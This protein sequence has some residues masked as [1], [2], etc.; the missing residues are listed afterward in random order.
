MRGVGT[1][2]DTTTNKDTPRVLDLS[3]LASRAGKTLTG[4][5]RVELAYLRRFLADSAPCFFL[6]RTSHGFVLMDRAGGQAFEKAVTT[7]AWGRADLQS[8]LAR[9]KRHEVRAAHSL[10]RRHRIGRGRH[11]R[12]VLLLT[13]YL[14]ENSELYLIGH[15]NL[16]EATLQAL[17]VG[18]GGNI[19]VMIHDTI[20]LDYPETQRQR[21]VERFEDAIKAV[22]KHAARVICISDFAAERVKQH[23]EKAGNVPEIVVSHLGVD[24][25]NPKFAEVPKYIDL[26]DDYFVI[27][28]TIEPRKNHMLLLEVWQS[29]DPENRPRLFVCGSRGWLNKTVFDRLDRGIKGVQE[30]PNL[31]DGA[32]AAV[33]HGSRALLCPS[34]VEGFGLT[35]VEAA[36]MGVPVICSS[37]PV[38]REILG[39]YADYRD[40]RD[41]F[42][43]RT[44]VNEIMGVS[45]EEHVTAFVPSTWEQHF[46]KVFGTK[47]A[48]AKPE[49]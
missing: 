2:V 40:P 35:P 8:Y 14:P 42:S 28:G 32:L 43:W 37:I 10:V 23:L 44:A 46:S 9:R 38:F 25:P 26:S 29:L 20:P 7:G 24:R 16:D 1:R 22:S 34:L 18:F 49:Q 4:I 27:A 47:S 30:Y 13:T 39:D 12:L 41:N 31:S 33:I 5:D 45:R 21:V 11:G 36:S 48:H 15:Q 6:C 3:R 17:D 19:N